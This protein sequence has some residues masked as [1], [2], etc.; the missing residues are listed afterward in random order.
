MSLFSHI[1]TIT[2]ANEATTGLN[3]NKAVNLFLG[4]VQIHSGQDVVVRQQQD[5]SFFLLC[6]SGQD[7]SRAKNSARSI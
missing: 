1:A 3:L 7:V 2:H 6:P 5:G 4:D